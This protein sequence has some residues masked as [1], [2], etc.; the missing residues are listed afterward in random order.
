MNEEDKVREYWD[1]QA[2]IHGASS[3]ATM[4]DPFLKELE[5]ENISKYLR[6]GMQVADLGCG[7]GYSTFR[8][9]RQNNIR[10]QG[11]DYSES[12]IVNAM[13]VLSESDGDVR[14]RVGFQSGDV[15]DTGLPAV[16]FDT[17]ITDRCLI[18]LTSRDDQM[19]AVHEVHRILRPGGL[20]LM[21]EDTE[22]GLN[23]LNRI[24]V[25]MGLESIGVRWHNLYLDEAHIVPGAS[26][27][28]ELITVENFSSFYYLSS[29]IIHA[30]LAQEQGIEP[31]YDSDINRVAAL[32][33]SIGEFG[34]FGPLKL[35][36]FRKPEQENPA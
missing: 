28:F 19:K 26:K 18:N 2:T 15:R 21:C 1:N 22:Q 4:P 25:A 11:V 20:Y 35:F 31:R 12:M 30:K 10:I 13:N 27:I 7:N 8:Y 23:N 29:R 3:L 9:A 24:R 14:N 33:S 34:D 36:V 17:V 6:D 16:S 32:F 5:I